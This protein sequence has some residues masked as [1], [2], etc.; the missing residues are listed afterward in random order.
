VKAATPTLTAG[1]QNG[2][3]ERRFTTPAGDDLIPEYSSNLKLLLPGIDASHVA[4]F[5]VINGVTHFGLQGPAF[6][7][8]EIMWSPELQ[9][10]YAPNWLAGLGPIPFYQP[11]VQPDVVGALARGSGWILFG[12]FPVNL[13]L[14]DLQRNLK[15]GYDPDTGV[16]YRDIPNSTYA[17][18]N[19]ENQFM[20]LGELPPGT[21]H[22][23][24]SAFGDGKFSLSLNQ[25]GNAGT[26][27]RWLAEDTVH[28]GDV[29]EYDIVIGTQPPITRQPPIADAGPDQTVPAV[30]PACVADVQLDGSRS[31]DPDGEV[32]TY[33]WTGPF[34]FVT[35]V[36]PTV[37]LP[38]GSN[39]ITLLVQDGQLQG[40]RAHTHVTVT[41]PK[42][43][44]NS[45]SATP[46]ILEPADGTMRSVSV[47][48]DV[49]AV[50]GT[51]TCRIVDVDS[52]EGDK[53]DWKITGALTVKLRAERSPDGDGRHYKLRIECRSNGAD[54]VHKSVTVKVPPPGRMKGDGEIRHEKREYKFK[55]DLSESRAGKDAGSVS[56]DVK[57]DDDDDDKHKDEHQS[58]DKFRDTRV[59]WVRFS[60]DD[61]LEPGGSGIKV[62][63]V[64]A[65]GAGT[66]N[67]KAGYTFELRATDAGEPGA[68]HDRFKLV[69]R[70]AKGKS[71]AYVDEKIDSGNNQ[72]QKPPK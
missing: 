13:L 25:L 21:Y 64:K 61:D 28:T 47:T 30:P 29:R 19:T 49:S 37:K 40:R 53:S 39:D 67:G 27:R 62:D 12:E 17:A 2:Q 63:T 3:P 38:V 70:D 45:I 10:Q 26:P 7:H 36:Q 11:Y 20:L 44:I 65:S 43:E 34:G 15:L 56:L 57:Y 6:R 42:A 68:H 8:K 31:S 50:C 58:T 71:V 5:R 54:P 35:G 1:W 52:D 51:A 72:S 4:G 23:K 32:L 14:T 48:V 41:A 24:V 9:A 16:V 33:Q 60:N 18:P 66:W 59:D 55:F 69:V 46:S 22:L